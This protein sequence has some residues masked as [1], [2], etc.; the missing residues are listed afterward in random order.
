MKFILNKLLLKK[1]GIYLSICF[2]I[3]HSFVIY[4]A[5]DPTI[6]TSTIQNEYTSREIGNEII[7][8]IDFIDISPTYWASEPIA[9]LGALEFIKGYTDKRYRP[10]QVVSNEE[11]LTVLVR[12]IGREADATLAAEQISANNPSNDSLTALWSKGY[13]QVASDI[14]LITQADLG[15]A[16]VVDQTMLDPAFN[17]MRKDP[18]TRE[19]VA[20]WVVETI[21]VQKP[22][23]IN[24]NFTPQAILTFDDL[25]D[26]G[27]DYAPY[28]EAVVRNEIMVGNGGKFKPKDSLTRAELVQIIKNIDEILYETMNIGKK[29][30]VVGAIQE[31]ASNDDSSTQLLIRNET[32]QVDALYY[33]EDTNTPVLL[34]GRVTDMTSLMEGHVVEYLVN[35][36]TNKLLYVFVENEL[37]VEEEIGLLQ[38]LSGLE[39]GEI[40]IEQQGSLKTFSMINSLYDVNLGTIIIDGKTYT[41]DQAPI[42]HSITL[43]MQNGLVTEIR[44]NGDPVLVS[45]ISGIV[46]ENNTT[47]SYITIVD[48]NGNII[49]KNYVKSSVDVEKQNY[50]DEADEIGYIDEMFPNFDFD[51]RDG[52]ITDIEAGDLVHLRVDPSNPDY[53]SMISAKTNY[54]VKYA[55]IKELSSYGAQGTDISVEFGDGSVTEYRVNSA[56]PVIKANKNMGLFSLQPGDVVKMLVNQ[57]VLDPGIVQETI[58]EI[59]VDEYGNVIANIYK[60]ELSSVNPN[61]NK[62]SLLNV[63]SLES[64]GWYNYQ[65]GK[66]LDISNSSIAYFNGDQQISLDYALRYLNQPGI[67]MYVATTNAHGIEMVEKVTFRDGRDSVLSYSTIA[68]SNGYDTLKLVN[69]TKDIPLGPGTIVIK[70]GKLVGSG[71]IVA[72]DYAQVILND[73]KAAVVHIEPEPN[74]DVISVFRGRIA[75]IEDYHSFQVQSHAILK[76]M[77]WIYSPIPR[78]FNISHETIIIDGNGLV[79]IDEFVSYSDLSKVD[80]VYT[81]LAD[82]TTAQ[83]IVKNPYSQEGVKGQIVEVDEED[84]LLKDVVVYNSE[85]K[86][87]AELSYTNSYATMNLLEN[88]LIIKNNEV[89]SKD[90]L[91]FGDQIRVLT[92]EDLA[93][94]VKESGTRDFD[95]YIIFVEN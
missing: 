70:N 82:G 79:D 77:E 60:G 22:G 76:G 16:L 46:K 21:N 11:A 15:S 68:Y 5:I 50:Y 24:P 89:I 13:L 3:S 61:Q 43:V 95:G 45:E 56:V 83:Y 40:T 52:A 57:A 91:E 71:S 59:V 75:T 8:N 85:T 93:L 30:G 58:K 42:S 29:S 92:T 87:W 35:N 10:T 62:L 78:I 1:I 47:F 48:W 54:V 19:Q 51:E 20:K 53:V 94:Q 25:G 49:T 2:L 39:N 44:S 14:G 73:A 84:I 36:D 17:F 88:A 9:R 32:G 23:T 72:P 81:I 64:N 63:Y 27:V 33:T 67:N 55:T 66:T 38:P 74:N 65:K 7:E 86:K 28:V 80:E 6:L 4:G 18:V 90:Q 26:I 12:V 37:V 31:E 69:D 34:E 41:K